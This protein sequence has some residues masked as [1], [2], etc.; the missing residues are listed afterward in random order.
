MRALP[1]AK[2]FFVNGTRLLNLRVASAG[3]Y[4]AMHYPEILLKPLLLFAFQRVLQLLQDRGQFLPNRRDANFRQSA[5]VAR[6]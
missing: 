2:A 6:R 3:R 5:R 4:A 1:T